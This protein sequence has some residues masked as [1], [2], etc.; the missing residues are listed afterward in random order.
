MKK[1]D[2]M[3]SLNHLRDETIAEADEA[4]SKKY[5][6]KK[7]FSW[8]KYA[9]LAA[10]AALVIFAGIQLGKNSELIIDRRDPS[11]T[12]PG[13]SEITEHSDI[14]PIDPTV[15]HY[16]RDFIDR[17]GEYQNVGIY[18]DRFVE[19]NPQTTGP[20]E[21]LVQILSNRTENE[22]IDSF[23]KI[24]IT[25]VIEHSEAEKLAGYSN[26][27]G[28]NRATFYRGVIVYDYFADEARQQDII[29]RM[30]GTIESQI[31]GQP[32][33]S[34]GDAI[35]VL[36]L[37][38]T[39]ASDI[40][41][42]F[43]SY[44]F[45]YEIVTVDGL[46]YALTRGQ[47]VP[48][49]E[50][51]LD[52]YL[53]GRYYGRTTTTTYNDAR[54]QGAFKPYDLA[55]AIKSALEGNIVALLNPMKPG[56]MTQTA[57][58]M[59]QALHAQTGD[60]NL[61]FYAATDYRL[62]FIPNEFMALVG[63]ENGE[64]WLNEHSSLGGVYTA[65]DEAANLYSMMLYFDIP[66]ETVREYLLRTR[67]L[68]PE[69]DMTDEEIDMLFTAAPEEI[70]AHFA[71]PY[72]I[73]KGKNLYSLNWIY[74]HSA[75]DYKAAGITRDEIAER[76]PLFDEFGL[77]VN[78]KAALK[79]KLNAY[80]NGNVTAL[81]NPGYAVGGND[82]LPID[83]AFYWAPGKYEPIYDEL[84]F[85]QNVATGGAQSYDE[86]MEVVGTDQNLRLV[87]YEIVKVYS[88][89]EAYEITGK[90]YYLHTTTLYRARVLYDY[91]LNKEVDYYIDI[92]QAGHK[93]NQIKGMPEYELGKRM[94]SPIY[95]DDGMERWS[96]IGELRY[97][98]CESG[99]VKLAY[100][101]GYRNVRLEYDYMTRPYPNIDLVF[102]SW[103]K[104][105]FIT[106]TA[107]NPEVYTQKSTLR[108]LVDWLITDWRERGII[109]P[110]YETQ[111]SGLRYALNTDGED[112]AIYR[113]V[114]VNEQ[115]AAT[116][117]PYSFENLADEY[118]SEK[119]A[120]YAVEVV[121]VYVGGEAQDKYGYDF[122]DTSTLYRVRAYYDLLRNVPVDIEFD[123]V[124][125]GNSERQFEG[126]PVFERG[127]KYVLCF[128]QGIDRNNMNVATP[129]L[130]FEIYNIDG[131]DLAYHICGD[132]IRLEG[133]YMNLDLEMTDAEKSVVTTTSNN[134][135][136]YTQKSTLKALAYFFRQEFSARGWV[137][138]IPELSK[139]VITLGDVGNGYEGYMA[140]DISELVN[141][142]PWNE[143]MEIS[144]LPV[145]KNHITWYPC[146]LPESLD[147]D[148]MVDTL[149]YYAELYG[150]DMDA[151]EIV[152]GHSQADYFGGI[153]EYEEHFGVPVPEGAYQPYTVSATQNGIKIEVYAGYTVDIWFD[154]EIDLPE[155]YSHS[156]HSS[157]AEAKKAAE[158]FKKEYAEQLDMTY[159]VISIDGGAYNIYAEQGYDI[160]L[161]DQSG[162]TPE[163]QIISYN[164]RRVYFSCGNNS[165]LRLIRYG[166]TDIGDIL[167]YYPIISS[168][169]ALEMLLDGK[170]ITSVPYEIRGADYV[171]KVEL[172][173]RSGTHDEYYIPYYRFYVEIEADGNVKEV[174]GLNTYG[175]FY[176]P[177]I[178]PEYIDE[179]T[180][181]DG[182]INR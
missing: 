63:Y 177:A 147:Y 104:L 158:Y 150:F 18:D 21:T 4:R 13:V 170:Y 118:L 100:H 12:E 20:D 68:V 134:P 17:V 151:L 3:E 139:L 135:V 42:L 93:E 122:H 89:E 130:E 51:E 95:L 92:S 123:V 163:S 146:Y 99:G 102:N 110:V 169:D 30:P 66:E 10:C 98:L 161:Y 36:T 145:F 157:Y 7:N 11:S 6:R 19:D 155:G 138:T 111:L 140:Y 27:L 109:S 79:Y 26:G 175:A 107:N 87:E 43:K 65:V 62:G 84:P 28:D 106:T 73:V 152:D 53:A 33:F 60:Y 108:S 103:D 40:T 34:A 129:E 114:Q 143:D 149:K 56:Y 32:P 64:A 54:Y 164:F 132:K 168:D 97:M 91:I 165:K 172:V 173:Y 94:F 85:T 133:D 31:N 159:P 14:E 48:E 69:D 120:I 90:D 179:M 131:T 82:E 121:R 71:S 171:K 124:H 16:S 160:F 128:R 29:F 47:T 178:A 70:A 162:A 9:A 59:P 80:I 23:Y 136:R 176:V 101:I 154:P 46:D 41:R 166:I 15:P 77:T 78:A 5:P 83:G 1:L 86:V 142:N 75:A 115:V 37:K 125:A 88:S 181:W 8:V 112:H 50:G 67:G 105:D 38:K 35:A 72:A 58:E 74:F 116:G 24:L 148:K 174:Y 119:T 57:D 45:V 167:G 61:D 180:V 117:Q 55:Q 44:A 113:D 126:C 22:S 156:Y 153:D 52:D 137:N 127:R 49:V 76:L 141:A 25:E 81:A 144:T 2:F 182:S 39:A 96:S